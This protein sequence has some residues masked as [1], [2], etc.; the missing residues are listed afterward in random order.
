MELQSYGETLEYPMLYYQHH[1]VVTS[2]R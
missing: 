2:F 1:P